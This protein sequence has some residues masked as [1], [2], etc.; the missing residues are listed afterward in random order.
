MNE[1][2]LI[3]FHVGFGLSVA[4]IERP[5]NYVTLVN[6]GSSIGFTP[7]KYLRLKRR[8]RPDVLYIT[9][10]HA[11]HLS[12][13]ETALDPTFAPDSICYQSYDWTDVASR[14]KPD[15]QWMIEDFKR[16]IAT[17][18]KGQ[19]SGEATLNCWRYTPAQA[20]KDFG[21]T[22]YVNASSYFLLY[23]WKDFKIAIAGDQESAVLDRFIQTSPFAKEAADTD[24]LVAPHHGHKNGFSQLWPSVL[25]KPY[26]TLI[27]VQDRDPHVDTRYSTK[28]FA[29]G[30][31][32]NGIT[33]YALTTRK[34][35]N[36]FVN[37]RYSSGTPTWSI[38]CCPSL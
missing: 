19:Y 31:E 8:L 25:G 24:L 28:D 22:R 5:A 9:H 34:D 32:I 15:C 21:D 29:R 6:L 17:A 20:R 10:P 36:I 4:L 33:R 7:L 16:L 13:V 30:F 3:V 12:D 14:E 26:L 2:E 18:P 1:L 38:Q 11:D 35:G 23:T 37:M 27:S